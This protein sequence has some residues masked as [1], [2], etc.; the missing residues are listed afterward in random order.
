MGKKAYKKTDISQQKTD[1]L[2]I[3]S[4]LVLEEESDES[5][6]SVLH[7]R[8]FKSEKCIC[9][10]CQSR[11][12][13]TS[14]VVTRKFKDVLQADGKFKIM[15]L[16]FHQRYLRCDEC[17]SSVFPEEIDF[18]EKG[19]RFTNRL[20]DLLADGTFRYSYKKV[21]DYYGVPASTASV[22][23]IMRRRIQCRESN[24]APLSTPE[25]LAII[26]FSYYRQLFP[27]ILGI[28]GTHIYC[29]D[30][31]EDCAEATYI[32]FFRMLDAM[33]IRHIYIEPNEELQNAVAACF[34]TVQ[35]CL[36]H[37][38]ILRHGQN[39]FI[40]IIHSDGKRFPVVHKDDKLT[41]KKKFISKHDASQIELGMS[42]RPR[43][44]KAY[45]HFQT[46]LELLDSGWKHEDLKTWAS[47]T[48]DELP[49]FFE[50][51]D[52]ADFYEKEIQNSL[53]PEE[54]PPRQYIA[55]VKGICD[56]IHEMPHCI[57][58]VLRGRCMFNITNDIIEDNGSQ[59]RLGIPADRFIQNIKNIT[60]NIKEDREYEL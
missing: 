26:E 55:V 53:Q 18:S 36:P 14:K 4:L 56:A 52:I 24:L 9:P 34:P 3:S 25:T 58:D 37:E 33:K 40:E 29:L 41:Q 44:H 16:I 19:S 27:L 23:S 20:S 57:F 2:G 1:A 5:S 47:S 15:D 21:C 39:A 8:Y 6:F 28:H 45:N 10:A 50:L 49:E 11:K 51:I 48:P 59:K 13:R 30:I 38:C 7:E 46:L 54:S 32:K 31:L 17:K 42:S 12:T 43:L 35:P 60:K 22:G